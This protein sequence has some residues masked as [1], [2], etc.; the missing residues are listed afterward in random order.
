LLSA[1]VLVSG[2]EYLFIRD[3]FL[4][5]RDFLINDGVFEDDPFMDFED[6]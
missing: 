6:F 5:R 1:E 2:D 3:A 4:Q